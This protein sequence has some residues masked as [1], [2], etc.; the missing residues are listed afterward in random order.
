MDVTFYVCEIELILTNICS[1]FRVHWEN[2]ATPIVMHWLKFRCCRYNLCLFLFKGLEDSWFC[3][4]VM[5]FFDVCVL[6]GW[7]LALAGFNSSYFS[8]GK[9]I[10]CFYQFSSTYLEN[11]YAKRYYVVWLKVYCPFLLFSWSA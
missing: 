4:S 3:C 9:L 10:D 1:I 8:L 5:R 11:G 2:S 7:D 6:C